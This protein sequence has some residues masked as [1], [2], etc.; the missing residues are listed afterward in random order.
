MGKKA[1]ELEVFGEAA[2]VALQSANPQAKIYYTLDGSTP[3]ESATAYAGPIRITE[4]CRLQA[5]AAE[6]GKVSSP[7]QSVYFQKSRFNHLSLLHPYA[8][9]YNGGGPLGLVDGR[10]GSTTFSDGRWQGFEGT[11]FRRPSTWAK[12]SPSAAFRP[13]S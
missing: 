5:I 7:A 9:K 6:P 11:D 10:K 13:L 8:E 12:S 3:T 1:N 4:T 2:E